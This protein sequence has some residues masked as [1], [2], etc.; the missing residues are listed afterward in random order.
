MKEKKGFNLRDICGEHIIVAEG[1]ENIDFC[2][3]ISMNDSA[4]YLWQTL[5]DKEF[6]VDDMV[7][8]L[9]EEY[10]VDEETA[11]KDASILA[12]QWTE[13]EIIE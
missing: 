3:I 7:R 1:L 8:L 4:A 2:N 5:K 11:K 6:T 10:D 12:K 9:L 13:A